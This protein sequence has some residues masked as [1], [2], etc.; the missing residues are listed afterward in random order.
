[1][2]DLHNDDKTHKSKCTLL[3]LRHDSFHLK[4]VLSFKLSKVYFMIK[5]FFVFLM[6]FFLNIITSCIK[7]VNITLQTDIKINQTQ[8]FFSVVTFSVSQSC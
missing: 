4:M 3:Q 7:T 2:L 5:V 6:D 1:M 8:P